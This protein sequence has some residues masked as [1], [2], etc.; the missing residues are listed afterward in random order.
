MLED[1]IA[2]IS[3]PLGEGG[4]GII[5]ISGPEAVKVASKVFKPK[6]GA[7]LEGTASH[8]VRLGLALDPKTGE[9]LD[10][11]LALVMRAPRSYTAEDVVELHCH[12]GPLACARVLEAVLK[13]GARL[14][15]PGEFTRRAYLNGRLDLAQA[16]AVLN[17][18]R[19][20]S[21]AGLSAAVRQLEG[22]LSRR[23]REIKD[24]IVGV[25]AAV[26]ASIDFPEEVGEPGTEVRE[27]LGKVRED[28]KGLLATWEE[29]KILSQ[30]IRIALVG[31]PNVGKS[32]LLNALL[33]EERAIVSD[34][35]GTTRD[36]IKETLQ[37]GGLACELVDTAGWREAA[38]G[39]ERM[40]IARSR[41][42]ALAADLVLLV[43]D[44]TV[45]VTKEDRE[46]RESL[47]DKPL[48]VVGNKVDAVA[49][50]E[51]EPLKDLAGSWP[52]VVVSA[53]TGAGLEELGSKVRG[54]V[55][56]G[57]ALRAPDE[58]LL[59]RERHKVA[60][61]RALEH[62]EDAL[63]GWSEGLPWDLISIDLR[64]AWEA[65]GE[66][67]GETAQDELLDRIFSEFCLGK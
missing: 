27:R 6:R 47:K 56:S 52:W 39:L 25:L 32:S 14:A 33:K 10:E 44:L 64:G 18:I 49:R 58:P 55:L 59:L 45:G 48:V 23:V 43:V 57:Q 31:R 36:T 50:A 17:I 37:L 67:T 20:R 22:S 11:V 41:E 66:I 4:I 5:R 42:A 19:A 34:I 60:L 2:A 12:G 61:E 7:P 65:V 53:K 1:T 38:E 21:R 26:E 40:G 46:I 51:V 28:L 30:G 13:A 15:E 3:T 16:E 29:G 35:P 62:V 24:A 9:V 63:A 8:R 54:L